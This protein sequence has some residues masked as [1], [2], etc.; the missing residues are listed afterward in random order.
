MRGF[1]E[2]HYTYKGKDP[3]TLLSTKKGEVGSI[4]EFAEPSKIDY[5]KFEHCAPST[6]PNNDIEGNSPNFLE[7]IARVS[8]IPLNEEVL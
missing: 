2:P 5:G 1:E 4:H 6:R 8:T 7:Q 3:S